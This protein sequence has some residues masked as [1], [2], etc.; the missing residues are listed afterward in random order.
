MRTRDTTTPDFS[1]AKDLQG[2]AFLDASG[3]GQGHFSFFNNGTG[4]FSPTASSIPGL[5]DPNWFTGNYAHPSHYLNIDVRHGHNV[6][7]NV[8]EDNTTGHANLDSRTPAIHTD[9]G[10]E[11]RPKNYTIVVWRRTN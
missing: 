6:S 2:I 5:L 11:A 4:V 7:G 3:M 9:G 8:S 10:N 1:T